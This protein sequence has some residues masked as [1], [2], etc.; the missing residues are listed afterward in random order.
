VQDIHSQLQEEVIAK[1]LA[2]KFIR[3]GA[4]QETTIVVGERQHGGE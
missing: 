4:M 2:L 1:P 3:G